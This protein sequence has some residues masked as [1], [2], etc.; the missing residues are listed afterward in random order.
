M[1]ALAVGLPAVVSDIPGNREWVTPG[2]EGFLVPVDDP[3][4]LAE[5]MV[6]MAR[7]PRAALKRMRAAARRRAEAQARWPAHLRRLDDAY[8]MAVEWEGFH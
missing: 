2:V 3:T 5:A 4:A 1:Q 7:L 8:R 6:R